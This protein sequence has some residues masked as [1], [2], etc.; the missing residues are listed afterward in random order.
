MSLLAWVGLEDETGAN[1]S[2]SKPINAG[3]PVVATEQPSNSTGF[4]GW[5]DD[6]GTKIGDTAGR[7]VDTVSD[8]WISDLKETNTQAVKTPDQTPAPADNK[9][10]PKPMS[11]FE[12]NKTYI[13]WG[14][15]AVLGVAALALAFRK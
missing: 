9:L 13:M 5:L 4:F 14:G 10:P 3:V 6:L 2:Q 12:T 15:V 7:A 8:N 1:T 11:F